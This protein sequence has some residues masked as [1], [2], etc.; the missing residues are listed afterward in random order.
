M[1]GEGKV[2]SE[3]VLGNVPPCIGSVSS[4][5]SNY[6]GELPVELCGGAGGDSLQRLNVLDGDG[7]Q[8]LITCHGNR[9]SFRKSVSFH[10][11]ALLT[12]VFEV[13]AW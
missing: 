8:R 13:L 3:K 7:V 10:V 4:V 2:R 12:C 5:V 6:L 11:F 1:E 9:K